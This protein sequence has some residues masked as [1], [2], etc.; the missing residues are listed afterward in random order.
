[1]EL[2]VTNVNQALSAGLRWLSVAGIE[3]PSRNGPVIVSPEPVMTVYSRPW[4][5]VLFSP[6]RDAN[7]LFHFMESLWMLAG[8][9][10]VEFPAYFAGNIRNYSDD[11]KTLHG[12]YGYRWRETMGYDQLPTIVNELK[13]NPETRRCVLQMWDS[14]FHSVEI[15]GYNPRLV[16][17]GDLQ[18]A[19]NGGKD[20]PCNTHIYFD[21]REGRLNMTVL[22]RSNDI[23]WGAYGAN[24]V[25]FSMLQ[26][27]LA[28][29]VGIPM[30]LYRQFSNNFHIYTN[31]VPLENFNALATDAESY[32]YYDNSM[33][34]RIPLLNDGEIIDD[35]DEDLEGF[36]KLPIGFCGHVNTQFFAKVVRPMWEA[37]KER[38]E[39]RGTGLNWVEAMLPCD[40]KVACTEWIERREA[41]KKVVVLG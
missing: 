23:Y 15:D 7:P 5:R 20:V 33:L 6:L 3:E 31:V 36:F 22:C 13:N 11:G 37:W 8:R 9:N 14:S 25:H 41:K 34:G 19:M 39:K 40:W 1:M 35:F 32:D 38:K 4:E 10:D 21:A 30:G 29:G 18:L 17:Q 26:E 12:A 16:G 27:Y 24:A 2:K 28:A